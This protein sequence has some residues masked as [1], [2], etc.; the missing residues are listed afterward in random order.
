MANTDH[1][2]SPAETAART[3]TEEAATAFAKAARLHWFLHQHLG[4]GVLTAARV[5]ALDDLDRARVCE[6]AGERPAS[7]ATWAAV[8]A[9]L[10]ADERH[11]VIDLDDDPFAGINGEAVA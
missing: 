11:S 5:R 6:L 7:P 2:P 9:L 3:T 10:D 4:F 8:I 1:H